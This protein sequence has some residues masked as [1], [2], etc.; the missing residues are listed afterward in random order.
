MNR[1]SRLGK[2]VGKKEKATPYQALKAVT[3]NAAYEHFEEKAKGSLKVG[4]SADLVILDK[5]PL[6]ENPKTL[7]DIK[8]VE[9]I[10]RGK[11]IF[12]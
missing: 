4:K 11:T 10:K 3:I 6:K 2:V 5:N 12:K 1:V 8:V 9:T 7:K